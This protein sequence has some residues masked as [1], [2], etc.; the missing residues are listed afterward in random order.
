MK[1][2]ILLVEDNPTAAGIM[3]MHLEFLGYAV[4]VA[5]DGVEAIK[6]A[7]LAPPDLIILDMRMPYMDGYDTAKRLRLTP[8]LKDVPILAATAYAQPGAR[9]KCLA[10][11]CHDYISKPFE[12]HQLAHTINKLLKRAS[13]ASDDG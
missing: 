6:I 10:S 13:E 12:H 2:R 8:E 3:R 7:P 1:K 11:G 9:E 4:S 5:N